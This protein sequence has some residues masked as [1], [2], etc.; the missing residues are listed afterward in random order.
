MENGTPQQNTVN[1]VTRREAAQRLGVDERT[2]RRWE[3]AGR[4]RAH[5]DEDGVNRYHAVDIDR[6]AREHAG[7]A[8][9]GGRV[10][11]AEQDPHP[12]EIA[13]RVFALLNAGRDPREVV[14]ELMLAP[15]VVLGL[16]REWVD[17]GRS[18][19]L[20]YDD[21]CRLV[22]S[23]GQHTNASELI[24]SIERLKDLAELARKFVFP[25]AVCQQPVQATQSLWRSILDA[26]AI[27]HWRHSACESAADAR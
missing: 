19:I 15:T 2:V 18:I 1:G 6:L 12:G 22:R 11:D 27:A 25:C 17:M 5:R 26:G 3:G 10:D 7:S 23:I 4:L 16:H 13:A 24:T 14:V 20:S 8:G 21:R 9:A